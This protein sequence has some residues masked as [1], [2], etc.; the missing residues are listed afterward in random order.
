MIE[1]DEERK[2]KFSC[3]NI[4][5]ILENEEKKKEKEGEREIERTK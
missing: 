4:D 3:H 1:K 2:D 5:K